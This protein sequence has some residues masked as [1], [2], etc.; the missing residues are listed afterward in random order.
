M[1]VTSTSGAEGILAANSREAIVSRSVQRVCC[2]LHALLTLAAARPMSAQ[3]VEQP[4]NARPYSTLS[5]GERVR[6][7]RITGGPIEARLVAMNDTAIWLQSDREVTPTATKLLEIST[8]HVQTVP[9]SRRRTSA[10]SAGIGALLGAVAGAAAHGDTGEGGPA[11]F[12]EPP[13]RAENLVVGA[14]MGGAVGWTIGR[15]VLA[16]SRWQPI[17]L[18]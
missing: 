7:V 15:F 4:T 16:R 5:A 10:V 11:G 12:G 14:V 2:A 9:A 6:I 1:H 17:V 18:P 13:S 3:R 8:L